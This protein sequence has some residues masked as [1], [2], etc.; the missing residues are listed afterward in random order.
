MPFDAY[1]TYCLGKIRLRW[2]PLVQSYVG[3]YPKLVGSNLRLLSMLTAIV[4]KM[5]EQGLLAGEIIEKTR[6]EYGAVISEEGLTDFVEKMRALG[7]IE[8]CDNNGHLMQ[9]GSAV[10]LQNEGHKYADRFSKPTVAQ[11][12]VGDSCDLRCKHCYAAPSGPVRSLAAATWPQVLDNLGAG[13]VLVIELVGGEPLL[14]P[15]ILDIVNAAWNRSF[16][17][18]VFSNLQTT[19]TGLLDALI[20]K[21][22]F[23]ATLYGP[24]SYHDSF[25]GKD[26]SFEATVKNIKYIKARGGVVVTNMVVSLE[27]LEF[28]SYV[29][30]LSRD[31]GCPFRPSP[32]LPGGRFIEHFPDYDYRT[33][34]RIYGRLQKYMGGRQDA[35]SDKFKLPKGFEC[36]GARSLIYVSPDGDV[37]PCPLFVGNKDFLAGN[38]LETSLGDLWNESKVL[39]AFADPG[40]DHTVPCVDCKSDNCIYWCKFLVHQL[41]G[42]INVAP[43]YCARAMVS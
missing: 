5:I 27:N 25:T 32:I 37:Y 22:A 31:L 20:D 11:V 14:H 39:G 8:S 3:V 30:S 17:L 16:C 38:I 19:D 41:T 10:S 42:S 21:V 13:G 28:V 2:E 9:G 40:S 4:L 1:Q 36:G 15:H 24:L 18:R 35:I 12:S 29:E 33:Y 43:P 34:V 6:T 23:L 26:G 7:A